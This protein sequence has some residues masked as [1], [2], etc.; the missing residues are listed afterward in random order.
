MGF[1]FVRALQVIRHDNVLRIPGQTA[2]ANA[3]DFIV[4][5]AAATL[6]ESA[7]LI[8]VLSTAALMETSSLL[9]DLRLVSNNGSPVGL[10]RG[11]QWITGAIKV[12]EPPPQFEMP[13]MLRSLG[14]RVTSS[15]DRFM[16]S[17]KPEDLIDTTLYAQTYY[18]D[19]VNGNDANSGLTWALRKKS[20]GAAIAAAIASGLPSRIL[21]DASAGLPYYRQVGFAGGGAAINSTVPLII[22]AMNGR[23]KTGPFDNLVW[24]KTSGA[25]YTYQVARAYAIQARNMDYLDE[26]G[27]A[28]QYAWVA[29]SAAVDAT[30]G[31]WYTDGTTVWIHPHN[32]DEPSIYNAR[33]DIQARGLNWACNQNLFLRGFDFEGGIEGAL[34]FGGG[35]TNVIVVDDCSLRYATAS[36]LQ[37]GGVTYATGA[38]ISSC[39]LFAGFN[40]DASRNSRDGFGYVADAGPIPG[41]LLVGCRGWLNGSGASQSNNGYTSHEGVKS[42]SVGCD[43]RFSYGTNSGHVNDNTQVWSV[44][45]VAGA[46]MGDVKLG[47]G[48]TAAAFGA[49][50]GKS[51]VWLDSCRDVGADAGVYSGDEGKIYVRNHRGTGRRVN[52]IP[53]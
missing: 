20:I 41:G 24:T 19:G 33:I 26:Y 5:D 14:F 7:G 28:R 29:S 38:R 30:E 25:T 50:M 39:G 12:H 31:S 10:Q 40:S 43:W 18:V 42:V 47:G 51:S 6:M 22:E 35:S 11:G 23:V 15:G 16:S 36:N 46:S 4:S 21:V 45:D 37:N 49:W 27:L 44:G 32:H 9:D 3:Q 8:Q 48:I 17:I 2:G 13:V 1:K 52:A 34:N 53:Y